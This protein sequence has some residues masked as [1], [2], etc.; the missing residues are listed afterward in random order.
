LVRRFLGGFS[1]VGPGGG[2]FTTSMVLNDA[3]TIWDFD[4]SMC[5]GDCSGTAEGAGISSTG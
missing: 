2:T 3:K 4:G 1:F 5:G